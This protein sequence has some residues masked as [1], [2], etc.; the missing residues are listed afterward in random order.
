[1][2]YCAITGESAVGQE[3]SF[4]SDA[5]IHNE[6]DF[7]Y[8]IKTYYTYDNATTNFPKIF[9]SKSDMKGLQQLA[10]EYLKR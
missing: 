1:M 10:D 7:D 2:A 5:S 9:D 4:C 6:F 8:N 3:Y